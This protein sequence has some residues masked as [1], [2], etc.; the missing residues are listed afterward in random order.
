M[1]RVVI[2]VA[3]LVVIIAGGATFAGAQSGKKPDCAPS[4]VVVKAKK[5][6][7]AKPPSPPTVA[8]DARDHRYYSLSWAK[9]RRMRDPNGDLLTAVPFDKL[10]KG[11][12]PAIAPK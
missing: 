4:R 11:A 12:N 7:K 6:A 1:C 3:A 2:A 8:Y 9:S 5:S 10:P